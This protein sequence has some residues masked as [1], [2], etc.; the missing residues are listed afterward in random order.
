M[1]NK[2]T[3]QSRAVAETLAHPASVESDRRKNS[4][5]EAKAREAER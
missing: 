5:S 1:T 3:E 2:R 4:S